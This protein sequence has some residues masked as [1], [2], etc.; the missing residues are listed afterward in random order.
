VGGACPFVPTH[1]EDWD[2]PD[3]AERGLAEVR[4]IRDAIEAR[5]IDLVEDHLEDI[6]ADRTAYELRLEQLLARLAEEF[7][8]RRSAEDIRACAEAILGRYDDVAVR[9]FVPTLAHRDARACLRADR[10][11]ALTA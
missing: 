10:C 1:V 5:V 9:S 3:P 8:G 2:I 6:R 4:I 7:A 11:H